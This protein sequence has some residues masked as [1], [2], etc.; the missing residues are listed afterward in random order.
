MTEK[1]KE[2][3][4]VRVPVGKPAEIVMVKNDLMSLQELVG[5]NIELVRLLGLE[6]KK[7]YFYVDEEGKLKNKEPN[8]GIRGDV[9]VGTAIV[10]KHD[11][12]GDEVGLT[13]VEAKWAVLFID[14]YRKHEGGLR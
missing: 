13:E 4:I 12:D 3:R 2:I 1:T 5:G 6:S 10:S 14:A 7:M 11:V 8:F 9:I